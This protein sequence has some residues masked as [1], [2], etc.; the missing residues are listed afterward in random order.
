MCDDWIDAWEEERRSN[1][2]G[3]ML[4]ACKRIT[5]DDSLNH[6]VL[7]ADPLLLLQDIPQSSDLLQVLLLVQ[8]KYM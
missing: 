8:H 3:A 2:D 7:S 5:R 4:V 1:E 6:D